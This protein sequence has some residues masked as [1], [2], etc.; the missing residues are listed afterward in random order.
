MVVVNLLKFLNSLLFYI[1]VYWVDGIA[2]CLT[3]ISL[4]RG[5]LKFQCNMCEDTSGCIK[6]TKPPMGLD[7]KCQGL[8]LG[9]FIVL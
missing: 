6:T 3:G 9:F 8:V 2:M 7:R 1:F 4:E 5:T